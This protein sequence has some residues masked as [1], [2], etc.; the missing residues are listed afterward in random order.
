MERPIMP[1]PMMSGHWTKAQAQAADLQ[2]QYP[3]NYAHLV[4]PL[5][6]T[7]VVPNVNRAFATLDKARRYQ[8]IKDHELANLDDTLKRGGSLLIASLATLGLKQKVF[9]VGEYLGFLSWFGAMAVTPKIINAAVRLKTGVNLNQLYD[10]TYGQ[11]LNLFNDPNYLPLQLLSDEQINKA[12]DKLKIP[13]NAPNRRQL[14]EEKMR[15]IS[16]Q[17]HTWWMLV[18]GPATPVISGLICDQLQDPATRALNTLKLIYAKHGAETA[19]DAAG[20]ARKSEAYLNQ[21][22]GEL[23][24]SSLSSWWKE[25]GRGISKHTGLQKSLGLKDIVDNRREGAVEKIVAHFS[26]LEPKGPAVDGA[27]RYLAGQRDHV[28]ALEKQATEFL[29]S[30]EEKLGPEA[31]KRQQGLIQTRISNAASTLTHY[32]NLF[33][34]IQE[35]ADQKTIRGLME[36]PVLSE[37]QRLLDTG[38]L[39]EAKKLIGNEAVY[40]EIRSAIDIRQFGKAFALMGASPQAHLLTALKDSMLRKLWQRRI[41]GYLGGG[42]LVATLLYNAIFVGRNFKDQGGKA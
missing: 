13:K 31:F 1:A 16:V 19:Q 32:E 42:M 27:L 30:R 40:K 18:A 11:R 5:P 34:A 24:E 25:F 37:V 41:L 22:V 38:Y 20:L 33:K 21:L 6:M 12:A 17:A 23:P 39:S 3:A 14:T 29:K 35:G 9:G 26:R 10:S 15:Q 2:K 36:R 28:N 7:Q 8:P 4:H